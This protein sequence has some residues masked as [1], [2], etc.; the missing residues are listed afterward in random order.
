MPKIKVE[1]EWDVPNDE[2]YVNPYN[3]ELTL[4]ANSRR[5]RFSVKEIEEETKELEQLC[6]KIQ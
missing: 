6:G 3:L 2:R 4:N 5:T 1:I